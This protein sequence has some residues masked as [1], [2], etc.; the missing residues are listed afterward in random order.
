MNKHDAENVRK[1]WLGRVTRVWWL[2]LLLVTLGTIVAEAAPFAY[3]ANQS[4]TVSVIDT[5]TNAV[6]ARGRCSCY[7]GSGH[8][9]PEMIYEDL[10]STNM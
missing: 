9:I 1:T 6:V 5:A 4:G 2:A 7:A 10:P 3:V 8:I